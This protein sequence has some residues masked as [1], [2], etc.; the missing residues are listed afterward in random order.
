MF[1]E[2]ESFLNSKEQAI[3]YA[4][5]VSV[6]FM[7]NTK[8]QNLTA[9]VSNQSSRYSALIFEYKGRDIRTFIIGAGKKDQSIHIFT[10]GAG[11]KVT[12]HIH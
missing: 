4:R 8:V 7:A 6:K 5:K 9:I 3:R 1:T 11:N 2:N 10:L 12:K